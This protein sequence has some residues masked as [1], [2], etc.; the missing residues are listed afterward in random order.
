[1]SDRANALAGALERANG[2]VIEFVS[3]CSGADWT[4]IVEPEGWTVGV[5]AHHIAEGHMKALRW[6]ETILS[7]QDVVDTPEA[8]HAE[9]AAHAEA[10]ADVTRADTLAHLHTTIAGVVAFIRALDDDALERSGAFG[11]DGGARRTV[12]ELCVTTHVERHLAQMRAAVSRDDR[13]R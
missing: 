6:M 1:M 3:S 4:A 13:G 8:H 12:A 2:V 7:G 10:Y 9:D 5:V 11:P